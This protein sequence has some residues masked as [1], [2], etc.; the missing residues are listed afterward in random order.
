MKKINSELF[1]CNQELVFLMFLIDLAELLL[2]L[3]LF[4]LSLTMIM[5]VTLHHAQPTWEQPLEPQS[6]SNFLNWWRTKNNSTLLLTNSMFKSEVFMES[7]LKLMMVPSISLT[8]EDSEDLRK[9][10]FKTWLM[11]LELL[12]KLKK[13]SHEHESILAFKYRKNKLNYEWISFNISIQNID[14]AEYNKL[15]YKYP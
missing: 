2:T 3:K 9:I 11:E 12:L 8:K 4:F 6:T 13:L 1:L 5:L 10:L 14:T 7:T 15:R